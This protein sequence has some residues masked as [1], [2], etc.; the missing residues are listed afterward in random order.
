MGPHVLKTDYQELLNLS[1][2]VTSLSTLVLL[3]SS[4]TRK[5]LSTDSGV[6]N[7]YLRSHPVSLLFLYLVSAWNTFYRN[8]PGRPLR[9]LKENMSETGRQALG[10]HAGAS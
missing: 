10:C 5:I 8:K 1:F 7:A 9:H 6:T 4:R 2:L 3:A